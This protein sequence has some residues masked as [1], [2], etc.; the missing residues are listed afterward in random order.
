[1]SDVCSDFQSLENHCALTTNCQH[2][3][4]F[5][6]FDGFR[7]FLASSEPVNFCVLHEIRALLNS[8]H[9]SPL[10]DLHPGSTTFK[11]LSSHRTV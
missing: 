10:R 6:A 4:L 11:S 5:Q 3:Q 8:W 9:S 7:A 1:M 2:D